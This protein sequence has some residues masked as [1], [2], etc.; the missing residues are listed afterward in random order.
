MP[1]SVSPGLH[2]NRGPRRLRLA[3]SAFVWSALLAASLALSGCVAD[4]SF[5]TAADFEPATVTRVID[6]DTVD[7]RFDD[8]STDR[9]RFIGVDTPCIS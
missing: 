1:A 7:V 8:G 6:G 2:A 5:Q 3:L 4:A 9:V